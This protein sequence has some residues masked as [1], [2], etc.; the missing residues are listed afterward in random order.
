MRGRD[1]EGSGRCVIEEGGGVVTERFVDDEVV[2]IVMLMKVSPLFPL[3]PFKNK[4]NI[5][6]E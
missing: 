3:N 6:A 4:S 5:H 2:E 1:E